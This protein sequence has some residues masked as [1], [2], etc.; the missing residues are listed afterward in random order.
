MISTFPGKPF[1]F[2]I[3][4]GIHFL[5][6]VNPYVVGGYDINFMMR[7]TTVALCFIQQT[8]RN[9]Y[10]KYNTSSILKHN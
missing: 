1:K 2:L 7:C 6:V 5:S 9:I 8:P 10:I 4:Y 3:E